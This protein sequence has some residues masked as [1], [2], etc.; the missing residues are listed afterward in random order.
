MFK[1]IGC[2]VFVAVLTGCG[3]GGGVSNTSPPAFAKESIVQAP[4]GY[5]DS[6]SPVALNFAVA[7]QQSA[8]VE[9]SPAEP[10][11]QARRALL[12]ATDTSALGSQTVNGITIDQLFAWGEKN[13]PTLLSSPESNQFWNGYT[14]RYY[15]ANDTYIG[16]DQ[17]GIVWMFGPKSTNAVFVEVAPVANYAPQVVKWVAATTP[18]IAPA[19]VAVPSPIIASIPVPVVAKP[20]PIPAPVPVVSFGGGGGGAPPAPVVVAPAPV[21]VAPAVFSWLPDVTIVTQFF[22]V[23]GAWW[24]GNMFFADLNGDGVEEIIIAGRMSQPATAATWK[25]TRV[26]ILGWNRGTL[27]L[28]NDLWFSGASD[29]L[30]FGTEP[31]VKFGDFNGDGRKDIWIAPSADM[32]YYG[33]G[34]AYINQ[35][36]NKLKKVSVNIG[37]IWAHDSAVGDV[38]GDGRDDIIVVGLNSNQAVAL[39]RADGTFDITT[40]SNNNLGAAGMAAGDF[41]GDGT[42]TVIMT[43]AFT[44]GNQTNGLY[45]VVVSSQGGG[46][47]G[48]SG[49]SMSGSS[50]SGSFGGGNAILLSAATTTLSFNRISKLPANRFTLTKWNNYNVNVPGRLP[51]TIRAIPI[52][53]NRDGRLDIVMLTMSQN[54]DIYSEVQFL[55]NNGSGNFTDVTDTV[56]KNYNTMHT[57]SS[58]S[59]RL[60]DINRDGLQDIWL[61]NSDGDGTEDT[62]VVLM[63]D[64]DGTYT[65][66]YASSFT[67]YRSYVGG[68][69]APVQAVRGPDQNLWLLTLNWTLTSLSVQIDARKIGLNLST[70]PN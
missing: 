38:N 49:L 12:A 17:A 10:P 5:T 11:Q 51:S 64:T 46:S 59:P 40:G 48:V 13:Y 33:P 54:G 19:P 22:D 57:Q 34:T 58:Y 31:S 55:R 37:N 15:P 35:G 4:A 47:G 2:L 24:N 68:N 36:G 16:V 41:M 27:G 23:L 62:N 61:S 8:Y 28:E 69:P 1:K 67:K 21:V 14:Y 63:A 20:V 70:L 18:V 52:D 30:I 66:T 45:R 53:F 29:N 32:D 42:T 7:P 39:G 65:A 3:G 50:G 25:Y 43:D 26:S 56:L 60:I 44:E 6:L 9:A